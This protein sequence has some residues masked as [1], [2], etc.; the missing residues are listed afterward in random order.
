[1]HVELI[2]DWVQTIRPY[3]IGELC[4]IEQ[5]TQSFLHLGP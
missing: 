2:E 5:D 3:L 1:M 4:H